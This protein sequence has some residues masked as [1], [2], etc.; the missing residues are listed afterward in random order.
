ML[1]MKQYRPPQ[2]A[3]AK[4]GI[5]STYINI[6]YE[7]VDNLCVLQPN[8]FIIIGKQGNPRGNILMH[9]PL[10]WNTSKMMVQLSNDDGSL[11]DLLWS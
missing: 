6:V 9:F 2:M 4:C 10:N 8:L 11:E 1:R 7:M 5:L 3:V